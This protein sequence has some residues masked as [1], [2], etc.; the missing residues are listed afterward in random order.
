[1]LEFSHFDQLFSSVLPIMLKIFHIILTKLVDNTRQKNSLRV[2]LQHNRHFAFCYIATCK[3]CVINC[4]TMWL[5]HVLVQPRNRS[6]VTSPFP[7]WGFGAGNETTR[8][9]A[10]FN[11]NP[12]QTTCKSLTLTVDKPVSKISCNHVATIMLVYSTYYASMILKC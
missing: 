4:T 12:N 10:H 3:W 2:I 6:N 5:S 9:C 8:P 1:M 11:F 7:T